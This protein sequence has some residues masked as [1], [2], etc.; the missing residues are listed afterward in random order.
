M[1][2]YAVVIRNNSS[3]SIIVSQM[4]RLSRKFMMKKHVSS[5]VLVI[6]ILITMV[7]PAHADSVGSEPATHPSDTPIA[8]F[9][10]GECGIL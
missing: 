8:I 9:K 1:D 5:A 4:H 3:N 7:F 2:S 10:P 6:A